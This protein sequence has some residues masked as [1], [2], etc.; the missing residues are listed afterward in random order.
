MTDTHSAS[1]DANRELK[2][3]EREKLPDRRPND[4][5]KAT[6]GGHKVYV[7]AGFY[8]KEDLRLVELFLD[9]HKE[10]AALR[11]VVNG[12]AISISLGLQ[13]GVP[14]E[15]YIDAFAGMRFEPSG[16]VQGHDHIKEAT[17]ILDYLVRHVA[18]TH[19]GRMDMID[20]PKDPTRKLL[21]VERTVVAFPPPRKDDDAPP[22]PQNGPEPD[23]LP[24]GGP[25][26]SSGGAGVAIMP[27]DMRRTEAKAR[28][29]EGEACGECGNFTLVRNG[30]CMKCNTCGSTS[31][32]S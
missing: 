17:S 16:L 14:F 8:S 9:M 30:T 13:Y 11:S 5:Q 2:R 32:C 22:E 3:G 24:V 29:Y 26:L 10:G 21:H 4:R 19:L 28:G 20:P 6:V 27:K 18:V 23:P 31:G 7:D 15:E 12:F 25:Q 1:P